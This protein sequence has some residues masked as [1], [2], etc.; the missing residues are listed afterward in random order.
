MQNNPKVML[1]DRYIKILLHACGKLLYLYNDK[2]SNKNQL[3]CYS[4]NLSEL[5]ELPWLEQ[6]RHNLK[7]NRGMIN[8]SIT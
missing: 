6:C 2:Q 1:S 7:C 3:E 8:V 5:Q 4:M